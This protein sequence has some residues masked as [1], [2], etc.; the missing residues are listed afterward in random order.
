QAQSQQPD[1]TRVDGETLQHFQALV[2]LDTQ[3]PPG[4]ET[5]AVD[6]LQ[7]VLEKE[8][9]SVQR[10]A[11]EPSRAN[12]VARLKGNGKKRPIL[13]MG[14]TDGVTV[15]P[16]KWTFP[17]FSATRDGGYIYGRGTLDT[18]PNVTGGLMALLM[19]KRLNVPLDRDVIFLAEAGEEGTTRVGIDYMVDQHFNDISAE[20]CLNEGGGGTRENGKVSYASVGTLEK[21]PRGVELT[22]HGPSGHASVPLTTNPIAH[23]SR[24]VAAVTEWEAPVRLNET[25]REYF[26]RMADI[27]PPDQSKHFRDI[28]SNDP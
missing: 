13:I 10:F 2:R 24:A 23:L 19:L 22:A 9:I 16:S 14:H 4:N 5:R 28:L 20:F 27:S 12:L 15:D 25:T 7:E 3:N 21:T 17:P 8:G 26:K 18:K 6:Y 1:W 11:L